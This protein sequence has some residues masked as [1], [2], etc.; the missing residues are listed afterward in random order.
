MNSFTGSDPNDRFRV[1]PIPLATGML[2]EGNMGVLEGVI[3]T[4]TMGKVLE[5]IYC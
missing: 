2:M 5:E 3:A 1:K 4:E